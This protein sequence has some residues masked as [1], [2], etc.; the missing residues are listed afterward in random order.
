MNIVSKY[1]MMK[2]KYSS[3]EGKVRIGNGVYFRKEETDHML[4]ISLQSPFKLII[5]ISQYLACTN[6]STV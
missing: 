1:V 3:I 5:Q 6:P 4:P 2:S